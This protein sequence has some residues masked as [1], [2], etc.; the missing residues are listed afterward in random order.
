[1]PAGTKPSRTS[2]GRRVPSQR[3]ESVINVHATT[4]YATAEGTIATTASGVAAMSTARVKLNTAAAARNARNDSPALN[5]IQPQRSRRRSLTCMA[6]KEH[7][8]A[9]P[10]SEPFEVKATRAAMLTNRPGETETPPGSPTGR[11]AVNATRI[12]N[13]ISSP[14][15]GDPSR[16]SKISAAEAAALK[17]PSVNQRSWRG[18]GDMLLVCRPLPGP[19]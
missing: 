2:R 5:G 6:A 10:N 4:R 16:T 18:N 1:M 19:P 3:Y 11:C 14:S 8:A 7:T 13:R 9:A 12:A 15:G 17:M